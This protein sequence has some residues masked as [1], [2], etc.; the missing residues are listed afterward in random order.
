MKISVVT[1]SFHQLDWLKF[2]VASVGDQVGD[3][4]VEH[5]IQDGGSGPEFDTWAKNNA[6][7]GWVSEPDNGMYDAI[8]RGFLRSGGEVLAWLN[9]DEQYLPGGLAAIAEFFEVNPDIDLV[10]GDTV[11]VDKTGNPISYR[12]GV[13]PKRSFIRAWHLPTFSAATFVRRRIIDEGNLLDSRWRTIADA[14]WID[15]LLAKGYRAGIV[16]LPIATFTR[17]GENLGESKAALEEM[18][19][20]R[21][22]E[23]KDG[24]LSRSMLRIQRCLEK[25]VRGEYRTRQ[26]TVDVFSAD[27]PKE[28]IGRSKKISGYCKGYG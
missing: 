27:S 6:P 21:R 26:T 23:G 18:R 14:T 24:K 22:S 16:G 2:C 9:C 4:E 25:L 20:W 28:R 12:K 13:V 15:A 7:R 3:F 5:L 8:N 17:T 11:M 19:R 1:P 10:F